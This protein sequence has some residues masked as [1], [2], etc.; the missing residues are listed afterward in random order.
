MK[1]LIG[2]AL[3]FFT[4][5]AVAQNKQLLYNVDALPQTLMTNPGANISFDGHFGIPFLSQIHLSVGSTGVNIHDI[6]DDSNPNVNQRVRSTVRKLT[7]LDYFTAH[8]E[9]E[10]ISVGWRLNKDHY[11]SAGIYQEM[12][13]FT[14]FPKD[15]ALLVIEGNNEYLNYPFDFSDVSF[16]GEVLA[17]YHLGLNKKIDRRLTV[18][19]RLKLYSGIFNVESVD[20]TGMF[21][22]RTTPGGANYFRHYAENVD[23]RVNTSGFTSLRDNSETVQE[24]ARDLLK[25]SLLG[26]NIGVGVDLGGTYVV[27]ES[28]IA[29]ASVQDV[30]L[31]FQQKDVEN[32]LYYGSYRTDGLEPL[33]PEIG[34]NGRAIPYWDIFEDEVD[35]NLKDETL[36][37]QYVT[38]RPFKVNASLQYGFGQSFAPCSYLR[39]TDRRFTNAVGVQI[40]GVNRPKGMKYAITGFYDRKFSESLR[41]KATYTID[42]FSY[43]NV[44]LLLSTKFKSFNFYLAADNLIGYLNLAMTQSASVQ[45]G[46]QFVFVRAPKI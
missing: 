15:P 2:F 12:D 46:F 11:L 20:N 9:I 14:Y 16:T 45:L 39:P 43:A 4:G 6:F 44:G 21:I 13:V 24:A 42:N 35:Q 31:M 27:N 41:M 30:G 22:T 40:F 33:F 8:E 10:I 28:M 38:W 18:G 23:I 32:Y 36:N 17:V 25:N 26:G 3:I 7:N 37:Q 34:P 5:I 29:T 1:F 19:G